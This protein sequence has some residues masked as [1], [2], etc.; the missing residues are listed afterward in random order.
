MA[1][2]LTFVGGDYQMEA[3]KLA[4]LECCLDA[5]GDD[6]SSG[7]MNNLDFKD[8]QSLKINLSPLR[9]SYSKLEEADMTLLG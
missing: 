7:L 5:G 8:L 3:H 6:S 9:H 2:K 4:L 1:S